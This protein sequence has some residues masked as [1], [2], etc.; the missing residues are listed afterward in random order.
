MVMVKSVLGVSHRGLTD[1][2]VQRLSAIYMAIF[3]LWLMG[4]F[5][6]HPGLSYAEWH[7]LF[8]SNSTKVFS[9]LFILAIVKHAWVGMW[10]VYTDY[11]KCAVLRGVLNVLTLFLLSACFLWGFLILWSVQ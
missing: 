3:V 6:L 11:I 2:I 10:T 5:L 4:F 7:G 8:A 1:W 9:L